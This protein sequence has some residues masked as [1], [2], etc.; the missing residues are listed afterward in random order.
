MYTVAGSLIIIE[1]SRNEAKNAKK[2]EAMAAKEAR[3]RAELDESLSEIRAMQSYL[4]RR[5]RELEERSRNPPS[6]S[7]SIPPEVTSSQLLPCAVV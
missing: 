5:V 3:V 4:E 1:Y 6:P 2:A 7:S